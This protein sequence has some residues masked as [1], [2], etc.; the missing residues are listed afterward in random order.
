M[1]KR[2]GYTCVISHRSGETEDS[3]IADIAV[4]TNA[5][6]IKTGSLSRS[7]RVAKYNQ[8]LRI[9]EYCESINDVLE[10]L[11][12][13]PIIELRMVG[14][15]SPDKKRLE[16]EL[17]SY[18]NEDLAIGVF[19]ENKFRSF[20]FNHGQLSL[21]RLMV[22]LKDHNHEQ[23]KGVMRQLVHELFVR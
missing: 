5:G 8:L 6:Q 22:G 19:H 20:A 4:A 7:D 15:T 16:L 14:I 11:S 1:A 2:A 17:T 10:A 23:I 13:K 18:K 3:T 12:E 9:E 21:D